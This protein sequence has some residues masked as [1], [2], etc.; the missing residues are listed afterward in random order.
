MLQYVPCGVSS[1]PFPLPRNG[2]VDYLLL[3]IR[4]LLSAGGG[5]LVCRLA[6]C[7]T[8]Q[9]PRRG[10][11]G[12]ASELE[13]RLDALSHRSISERMLLEGV[14]KEQGIVARRAESLT[15]LMSLSRNP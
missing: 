14:L 12:M 11:L 10:R 15:I 4:G 1:P 9:L 6:A 3:T 5:D 2:G 8:C 7:S 13:S